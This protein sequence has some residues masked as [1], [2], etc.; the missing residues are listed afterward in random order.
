M[1]FE[2]LKSYLAGAAVRPL[3]TLI[4]DIII[5]DYLFYSIFKQDSEV[6][7]HGQ[8]CAH[9]SS[10]GSQLFNRVP[11][12]IFPSLEPGADYTLWKWK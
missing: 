9:F 4:I 2:I 11:F 8:Q 5:I 3:L 7:L 10:S 6:T 12:F 1:R